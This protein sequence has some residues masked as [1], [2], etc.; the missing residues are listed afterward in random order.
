MSLPNSISQIAGRSA[1]LHS[2]AGLAAILDGIGEGFY[3]VDRDWRILLFNREAA[4]HLNCASEDVLGRVL[5][6]AFPHTRETE[7]GQLFEKVMLSREVVRSEIESIFFRGRWMA[8]R[9]FPLGEGIGAVFRDT[10]DRRKAEAQR[11]IL[12]KE[13][14]HR[15]KNTLSIVQ[16]MASQTFRNES[17]ALRAFESRLVALGTAHSILTQRHW[18]SADLH[19]LTLATLRP[20]SASDRKRF[21]LNGPKLLLGPKATVAFSMAVHELATNAAKYG[22]LSKETG[23]VTIEWDVTEERLVWSWREVEGPKVLPPERRGFGTRMIE[24]SLAMQ[25][26]AS[27]TIDYAPSGLVCAVNAPLAAIRDQASV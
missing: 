4:R 11:D 10:T 16:A 25:L 6:D 8:F 19:E 23:Y 1:A 27:I 22:A 12:T 9:L 2:E 21:S 26:S 18:D 14:E 5:W 15:L 13:L 3:A 7:L 24:R 20:H 17:T